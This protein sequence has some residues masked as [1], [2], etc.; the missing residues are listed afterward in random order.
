MHMPLYK[1]YWK[2]VGHVK[3]SRLPEA[4]TCPV[5]YDAWELLKAQA[6]HDGYQYVVFCKPRLTEHTYFNIYCNLYYRR[7]QPRENF[8]GTR[9]YWDYI[10]FKFKYP[11][12]K[13]EA[14]AN[15]SEYQ[16]ETILENSVHDFSGI[17]YAHFNNIS[18]ITEAIFRYGSEYFTIR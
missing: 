9:R 6:L 16:Q 2:R 8:D 10:F 5:E 15:K 18:K 1:M 14:L 12:L 17:P 11:N 7:E 3:R 4:V 13:P